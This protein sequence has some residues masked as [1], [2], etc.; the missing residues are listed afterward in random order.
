MIKLLITAVTE[1]MP[2]SK[3]MP[4]GDEVPVLLAYLPSVLSATMYTKKAIARKM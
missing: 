1:S 2:W 3:S 4:R